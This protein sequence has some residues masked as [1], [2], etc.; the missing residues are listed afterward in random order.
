MKA[1][2]F[3]YFSINGNNVIDF[4]ENSKAGS[5]CEFLEYVEKENSDKK[6]IIILDN[7]KSHHAIETTKK[8]KDLGIILVFL[9]PYSPDL[10]PIEFIWKS[11]KRE[12]SKK[13]IKLK[14]YLID[15]IRNSFMELAKSKSFAKN[16]MKIFDEQIKSIINS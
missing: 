10:N 15:L 3:A 4:K 14:K 6:I 2:A 9:P 7:S 5:V 11:I 1:N 13:S 12:I 8:A 16:W